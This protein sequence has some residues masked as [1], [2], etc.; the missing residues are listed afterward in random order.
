MENTKQRFDRSEQ[1]EPPV[2][3]FLVVAHYE[4]WYISREMA[5]A[6]EASLNE[7]PA[8]SGSC[9]WISPARGC[10]WRSWRVRGPGWAAARVVRILGGDHGRLKV[11]GVDAVYV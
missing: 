7:V 5:Q 1:P 8:P 4:E 6:I 9:L 10:A 2:D 3:Y 11:L